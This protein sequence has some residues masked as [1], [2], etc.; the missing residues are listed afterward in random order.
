[1]KISDVARNFATQPN[2]FLWGLLAG[3]SAIAPLLAIFYL[4]HNTIHLP[5][6]QFDVFDWLAR[7]LPG[8][9][10]T[11]GIDAL[12]RLINALHLK[13]TSATAKL[14]EQGLATILMMALGSFAGG[15]FFM[16]RG[17]TRGMAPGI[18]LGLL[19]GTLIALISFNLSRQSNAGI[20]AGAAWI[21]GAFIAWGVT[22]NWLYLRIF[23]VQPLASDA[24]VT[25]TKLNRRQ[26][27]IRVG[28]TAAAITVA[29]AALGAIYGREKNG[30][31]KT[32]RWSSQN[33]LPNANATIKPA[34]GTRP[35][36][37]PLEAH[38]RIDIDALP[39][40]IQENNWKLKINGLVRQPLELT[41]D[42][43]RHNY[44]AMNQFITLAC[45]SNPVGGDLTS[46]QRWTGVSL[47]HLLPSFGLKP[48]ATHLK[49]TSADG[50]YEIVALSTITSDERIMLAYAWDDVPL[51]PEHGFPLRIYIPDLYGMK[52]PK[53]ILAIEAMDHWEAG[54][55]VVRGWDAKAQ[56]K[57]T[58]VIDA[59]AK[60]G[61]L[62]QDNQILVPIG[63]IAH[64]GAR[65]ISK[66]Q[67]SVDNGPW[68]QA[69]LRTPISSLTWVLWRYEWPL[70]HGE[71]TFVVRC[72][73]LAGAP[74]LPMCNLPTLAAPADFIQFKRP[75]ELAFIQTHNFT[76][77]N[78]CS[79]GSMI[80]CAAYSE[81]GNIY[82]RSS[83]S[84]HTFSDCFCT[85][86]I[87][88]M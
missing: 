28:S 82:P 25:V 85:N 62:H 21:V 60:D 69:E 72:F 12:V 76:K 55:W 9:L 58:A 30:A 8:Q 59:V 35:E 14:A 2:R 53:W 86:A 17:K 70:T 4:A 49:I 46:T 42:N 67:V 27:V 65:G 68:Q 5:L 88:K 32:A 74:K 38:Y 34:P 36:F 47:Q 3:L 39:V 24:D 61:V 23:S 71:H 6:V 45:I 19:V 18:V 63:G 50:F 66:V 57:S 44:P 77:Q 20:L 52:Q 51:L 26:F 7:V 16:L 56:M 84:A 43:L 83:N 48:E 79:H 64:A 29:G 73:D 81:G 31:A 15:F 41:L 22:L 11:Y 1:M 33:A 40:R 87:D 13:Q 37:T 75:F 78:E 54:Y 10:L 80:L